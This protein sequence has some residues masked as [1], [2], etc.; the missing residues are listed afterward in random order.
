[1]KAFFT[2]SVIL[3]I[4]LSLCACAQP[5]PIEEDDGSRGHALEPIPCIVEKG[6]SMHTPV[7]D[8]AA[9]SFSVEPTRKA[10][11]SHQDPQCSA[12]EAEKKASYTELTP[13][14]AETDVY[15]RQPA[16][17]DM[18]VAAVL[19]KIEPDTAQTP[20]NGSIPT[21]AAWTKK[22]KQQ[23]AETPIPK[24][25][26]D[27]VITCPSEPSATP[28]PLPEQSEVPGP[29][30]GSSPS[31]WKPKPTTAP[32]VTLESTPAPTVTPEPT[33]PEP[34]PSA[35]APV[36]I[37]TPEPG[38]TPKPSGG[39]AVCSCGATVLPDELVQHMKA[40]ALKGESHSYTAH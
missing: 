7:E 38:A 14:R 35:E 25:S 40:H 15:G 18:G 6:V 5:I 34:T 23:A 31:A 2:V 30:P 12:E 26:V 17:D 10:A 16:P 29:V 3:A 8:R 32:V 13:K 19:V 4:A 22:P 37:P 28:E 20:T 33:V 24:I 11:E 9:D 1:M 36:P 21:S 27:F 39:Y